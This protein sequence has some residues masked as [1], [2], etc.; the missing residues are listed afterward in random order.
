M[1]RKLT[2]AFDN[3]KQIY[4]KGES[5]WVVDNFYLI[6]R[7]FDMLKKSKSIINKHPDMLEVCQKYCK[8]HSFSLSMEKLCTFFSSNSAFGYY[9]LAGVPVFL[10]S[11]AIFEI[12]E[13]KS[14]GPAI[15]LLRK[16]GSEDFDTFIE[17]VSPA[18]KILEA[19]YS[20]EYIHMDSAAKH[21]YRKQ[22]AELAKQH[23]ITY[24][25]EADRLVKE[26]YSKKQHIGFLLFRKQGA[27]AV[28]FTCVGGVALI[29]FALCW[30]F[31]GAYS[32]LAVLPLYKAAN[33]IVDF[34]FS[35][36][37]KPM[38]VFR[39][40]PDIIKDKA[41]VLVTTL[42][43]GGEKDERLFERIEK[44]YLANR[45][46][47]FTFG[48]LGDFRDSKIPECEE[49]IKILENVRQAIEE[50]NKKYGCFV[51]FV[52][53]RVINADGIYSG[54]ER[55]RGA[56]VE[57]VKY[58]K[59]DNTTITTFIGDKSRLKDT[60]YILTLD[61]DTN[62]PIG[63]V[64]D[65]LG[66]MLHP[67]SKPVVSGS[68]VVSGYAILQPSI[69]TSLE[70]ATSSNFSQL[71]S[72]SGG[73]DAYESASYDRYQNILGEGVFCGKGIFEVDC[74]YN[75]VIPQIP[76][77]FVL[78]H[79][80]PEGSILRT[81]LLSD[82]TLS[83]SA[84][85]SVLSYYNR[86]SRWI[87]GDIQNS[88]LL[89]KIKSPVGKYMLLNNILN[90]F[91]SPAQIIGI[92][93]IV[94]F[95]VF[96]MLSAYRA[97]IL[98]VFILSCTFLPSLLGIMGT[99]GRIFTRPKRRFF[100]R[101]T[102]SVTRDTARFLYELAALAFTAQNAITAALRSIYRMFF[103]GKKLLEWVTASETDTSGKNGLSFY[104]TRMLLSALIGAGL[105]LFAPQ[106][107]YK[108]LGITWFL[109]PVIAYCLSKTLFEQVK[110]V[111]GKN[112][113][114]LIK[115][116]S[117]M[118]KFFEQYVIAETNFLPPDNLQYEPVYTLAARTS[119]TNIGLYLLSCLAAADFGLITPKQLEK[120]LT[121]TL[122]TL[123]KM[124]KWNGHLYNWYSTDTLKVI[125]GSYVSSVD[126]GNFVTAVIALCEGLKEYGLVQLANRFVVFESGADFTVL[127]NKKKSLFSLGYD[128]SNQKLSEICYDLYMSEAR[129]TSY[130]AVAKGVVPKKNWQ[131]LS[132]TLISS[133]GYIGLASW[134]GTAFEYFMPSL[135]LPVY[136]NSFEYEALSFAFD[137]QRHKTA[138]KN[139]VWGLSE[140]AFFSFDSEMNYQY[141]A[142]GVQ[143]LGLKRYLTD[144]PVVSP[145]S[146]FLMLRMNEKSCIKNL[147]ELEKLDVTGE[148]GF[149]EAC[150][151][152]PTRVNEYAVVKS[153]MSHHVGMSI[154]AVAN[155][156]FAD[157]FVRRFLRN[158]SMAAAYEL[159]QERIPDV[160]IYKDIAPI[161]KPIEPLMSTM[162]GGSVNKYS[163]S[164]PKVQLLYCGRLTM[165]VSDIGHISLRFGK[166]LL[167]F[168]R[169]INYNNSQTLS[170]SLSGNLFVPGGNGNYTFEDKHGAVS[171]ICSST[172]FSGRAQYSIDGKCFRIDTL[173]EQQKNYTA[174]LRF[175]VVL[176]EERSFL[177]HPAFSKLFITAE[178]D[179]AEKVI[180]F[181][182]KPR[183]NGKFYYLAVALTDKNI[184]FAFASREGTGLNNSTGAAINP[185]CHIKTDEVEGGRVGFLICCGMS[186]DEVINSINQCRSKKQNSECGRRTDNITPFINTILGDIFYN[187]PNNKIDTF[188]PGSINNLW[189]YRISGDFP[190]LL[191]ETNDEPLLY[192]YIHVF[193][194]LSLAQIRC[195]L[196]IVVREVDRYARESRRTAL[197]VVSLLHCEAFMNRRGGIFIIDYEDFHIDGKT[198]DYKYLVANSVDLTK[199]SEQN[200]LVCEKIPE[201]MRKLN[202]IEKQGIGESEL[203][204]YGGEFDGDGGFLVDKH[205]DIKLEWS[206]V[207]A[208]KSFGSVQTQNSLGFTYFLNSSKNRITEFNNNPYTPNDGEQLIIF[209]GDKAYDLCAVSNRV[210]FKNGQ[211]VYGGK[212]GVIEF[213][214]L[215]FVCPQFP[216]KLIRVNRS[217]NSEVKVAFVARPADGKLSEKV[218]DNNRVLIRNIRQPDSIGFIG[219]TGEHYCS[220]EFLSLF[221]EKSGLCD[222]AIIVSNAASTWFYIG[223]T[224]TKQAVDAIC[225]RITPEFA[226]EQLRG[227]LEFVAKLLPQK[228]SNSGQ[229]LFDVMMNTFLPYQ[230]IMSRLFAKGG[231]YQVGGAYG[232]RDQLQ[233]C[234]MIVKT[235]PQLVRVQLIRCCAH[236]YTDGSVQHW[237]HPP[238]EGIRTQCSD[239]YLWLP[240]VVADYIKN[241]GDFSILS[242]KTRYLESAP[243]HEDEVER[244]EIAG[245]TEEKET[246]Y[247]HCIRALKKGDSLGKHG[248]PL[249]GS[250]DWNDGF[251]E[252]G[253][254]GIGESV[255]TAWLLIWAIEKFTEIIRIQGDSENEEGFTKTAKSVLGAIE[256]YCFDG[257]RY[258]RAFDDSGEPLGV[259]TDSEAAIDI[260]PQCFPAIVGGADEARVDIALDMA[261][262]LCFDRQYRI[263][264]L[265]TPPFDKSTRKVGYIQG[266]VPGIRENGG[267]YTHAAVWAALGLWRAGKKD[268]AVELFNALN[269][270]IRCRD[271]KLAKAYKIEPYVLAGDIYA[272][273]QHMGRGGWSWYTGA[274]AWYYRALLEVFGDD[275][276]NGAV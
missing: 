25:E 248:L 44:F 246:V 230:T 252:V 145:Y 220:T 256:S 160:S 11:A 113:K 16:L 67:L 1:F 104:I 29:F 215:V 189:R 27:K 187:T 263:M 80:M 125:G 101:I 109:F 118:W 250:C 166:M 207:I 93:A 60:K 275:K 219:A 55:K 120:R 105:F 184:N 225:S 154:I 17:T 81:R 98:L 171:H 245:Q 62:L 138:G 214:V 254:K 199:I 261:Y 24:N 10:A 201:I 47:N 51:L 180:I 224:A 152:T 76:D 223:G 134:T 271:E 167:N 177:A 194:T 213:E 58:I 270:A 232:F 96:G 139:A 192:E 206:Y 227:S 226:E 106:G 143:K 212:A 50:L 35:F 89:G 170:V 130:Y 119:P 92:I 126:S 174:E 73:I 222:S 191:A 211:C 172:E 175:D 53:K 258:L 83:D 265:F 19:E 208:N 36:I 38:P 75:L 18:E 234:L 91:L 156:C 190:V 110:T 74:F 20:G 5:R 204:V 39:M 88:L 99:P 228:T 144:E 100:S 150:D 205:Q 114:Y 179:E 274:A 147:R 229:P 70:S 159:L 66:A 260:L 165:L 132:R 202:M 197:K 26:S 173:A 43:F 34:I 42:L 272:N 56:V 77:G 123:D 157:V 95:A 217:E 148:Y 45:H 259:A 149:F 137:K 3:I 257:D 168:C 128:G 94:L 276:F 235:Q 103:S 122:I 54:Y 181:A 140:S 196:V 41:L 161:P 46:Q 121:D 129:T 87:R 68:R 40:E 57:A 72:G 6:S 221:D 37:I 210:L 7:N 79:D 203:S 112:R 111:S 255:F 240:L 124:E 158:R 141:K 193:R 237:W 182:R 59:G 78:S 243:L 253:A 273:P 264:K 236:Q 242:V 133:G 102:H 52:R 162:R 15:E 231:F 9:E 183:T 117:A 218:I 136:K 155:A 127:Y 8:K 247:E 200:Q 65:M 84:P 244:Y 241:T 86:S 188:V 135:L 71:I 216:I 14:C 63:A 262:S 146:T 249:M 116:V 49:D 4:L 151:F 48:I 2:A 107:A 97:N 32:L 108:V 142:F 22:V 85:K 90:I 169:F 163:L 185:I 176:D 269:P 13:A 23:G 82:V 267:Q 33:I 164:S 251:S 115:N 21:A 28:F 198:D 131:K 69:T 186:K 233:D 61:S 30:Y 153:Y 239:D 195:E 12:S 238:R 209:V 268:K 266:Y 31:C 178:H 64:A